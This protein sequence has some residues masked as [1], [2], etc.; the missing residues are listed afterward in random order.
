M[1]S[2]SLHGGE[3]FG[4]L[5]VV[6]YSHSTKRRDGT[7]GERIMNCEC[8]CGNKVKVRTSNLKSGNTISCGC[9]KSDMAIKSNKKRAAE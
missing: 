5:T 1:R 8:E 7:A 2:D 4:R 6:D 9:Y 3:V